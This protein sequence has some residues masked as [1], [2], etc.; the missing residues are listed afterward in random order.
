[1]SQASYAM[2]AGSNIRCAMT[3]P[4][5]SWMRRHRSS[6]TVVAAGVI[7]LGMAIADDVRAQNSLAQEGALFL[8]LPV[9]A[10]S[11]VVV[12]Q[13]KSER[14][15]V[16]VGP[17]IDGT[18]EVLEGLAL[19]DT[20]IVAGQALLRD[21]SPIRVVPPIGE[22]TSPTVNPEESPAAAAKPESRRPRRTS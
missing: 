8:L 10:R 12:R 20:V 6:R 14:R 21:G 18:T 1:M 4:S 2:R 17:D 16:R 5:C 7:A 3:S 22:Q 13:G 11:V 9:G 15:L 19:G